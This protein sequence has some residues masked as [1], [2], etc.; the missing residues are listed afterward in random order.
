MGYLYD[1]LSFL[2]EVIRPLTIAL[3]AIISGYF[4]SKVLA[5]L[6]LN[7][8]LK[9][10]D[11]EDSSNSPIR[12]KLGRITFWV[13]WLVFIVIGL[14]Q[15]PLLSL[16][17]RKLFLTLA[18]LP[19]LFLLCIG[20]ILITISEKWW[21]N[22]SEKVQASL[23]PLLQVKTIEV[24]YKIILR[25]S[26]LILAVIASFALDSP[27][28]F[29]LKVV[30]SFLVLIFGFFLSRVVKSVAAS[31]IGVFDIGSEVLNKIISYV[32]F[33]AFIVTAIELWV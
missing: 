15:L 19:M 21:T 25:L 14:N 6:V 13:P 28:S 12:L 4:L 18:N 27:K 3:L 5:S 9:E 33:M 26:L 7:I 32:V 23:E 30:A 24:I 1:L 8:F 17:L 16:A 11:S 10:D 29:G 22:F 2:P 20:A 31:L